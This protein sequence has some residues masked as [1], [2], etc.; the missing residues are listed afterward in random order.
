VRYADIDV[1]SSGDGLTWGA[2][3]QTIQGAIYS[4]ELATEEV[5]GPDWC[6]VWVKDGT[7]NPTEGSG[8]DATFLLVPNVH[9]Y[10]GFSDSAET[11]EARD[12]ITNVTTLDGDGVKHVVTG[13]DDSVLDGFTITGGYAQTGTVT[14]DDGG[15]MKNT[16]ASPEVRNC[17]F[18]DNFANNSGGG[19]FNEGSSSPTLVD[20]TFDQNLSENG[21]GAIYSTGTGTVTITGCTFN[22]NVC[23]HPAMAGNGGA[24]YTT[25][26]VTVDI[27]D[28]TFDGNNAVERGGAIYNWGATVT[29]A[30]STFTG[31]YLPT[32]S[33]S[34]GGAV[35]T[36]T[37]SM[38]IERSVF[39]DNSAT[40]YGRGGA[41]YSSST[42]LSLTNCEI[43]LNT[44]EPSGEAYA[45]GVYASGSTVSIM[46][47]TIYGNEANGAASDA[48]FGGGIY[49]SNPGTYE[50]TNS[51]IWGN[52]P[53]GVDAD[54][55]AGYSMTYTD[56]QDDPG[57]PDDHN[58]SLN[59]M[60]D[61]G[62]PYDLHLQST[63]PCI[64]EGTSEDAPGDDLDGVTR[65]V[66]DGYDM[67]CYEYN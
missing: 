43:A 55:D 8:D 23:Q 24:I 42:A 44:V 62:F 45:G 38:T 28:S 67:G 47:C 33:T 26:G 21:G 27:S 37:G 59:P 19:M 29:I 64:D 10:G 50:V 35:Y 34:L 60:F 18:Y 36:T 61:G 53:D 7:Y 58:I 3:Y 30:D 40:H 13:A 22:A 54:T 48:E 4:A 39:R 20:C 2:A 6:E 66:G 46:N 52:T 15:G 32:S 57:N 11:W 1:L 14:D 25:S 12:W 41:I 49:F 51:I 31:N 9:V 63:S 16:D 17:T 5:G 65:P 56:T